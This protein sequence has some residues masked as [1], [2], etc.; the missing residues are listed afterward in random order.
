MNP[1]SNQFIGVNES[2]GMSSA[3]SGAETGGEKNLIKTKNNKIY[4]GKCDTLLNIIEQKNHSNNFFI[5]NRDG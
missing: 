4:I 1:G 5:Y 2:M 3:N